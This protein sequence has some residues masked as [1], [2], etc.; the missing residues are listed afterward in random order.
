MTIYFYHIT[1]QQK[2]VLSFKKFCILRKKLFANTSSHRE[3][4]YTV[5]AKKIQWQSRYKF[6]ENVLHI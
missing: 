3:K 5:F 2:N 4:N 1:I 6:I